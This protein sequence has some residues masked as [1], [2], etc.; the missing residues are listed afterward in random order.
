MLDYGSVNSVNL[1]GHCRGKYFEVQSKNKFWELARIFKK[2]VTTGR[3]AEKKIGLSC[4]E[5]EDHPKLCQPVC[6]LVI[7]LSPLDHFFNRKICIRK[8]VQVR[9]CERGRAASL[10][11]LALR[12][13]L[14]PVISA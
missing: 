7:W 1:I 4:T 6:A 2:K 14:F 8:E 9:F 11:A 10:V 13:F 12:D 3:Q 5:G